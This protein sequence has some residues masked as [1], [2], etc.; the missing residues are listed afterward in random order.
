ML[1]IKKI[2]EL[3]NCQLRVPT[4]FERDWAEAF[5]QHLKFLIT[6][7][8]KTDPLLEN[9][10]P[11]KIFFTSKSSASWRRVGGASQ[12]FHERTQP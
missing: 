9:K 5:T 11:S 3:I 2:I 8:N 12:T 6:F 7:F 1:Y 10:L 4:H